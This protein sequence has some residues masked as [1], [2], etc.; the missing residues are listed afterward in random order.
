[1][2]RNNAALS[3]LVGMA[4]LFVILP[5]SADVGDIGNQLKSK[6]QGKL[7][8]LR[9]FY[10]GEHLR[11]GPDGG[12]IDQAATG[13]WTVN[14]QLVVKDIYLQGRL[15]I[16]KGNRVFLCFDSASRDLGV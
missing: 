10:A 14:A 6:Y 12:L 2:R 11:F 1:M 5:V 8:T 4:L 7:V 3:L 15:L 16:I 9:H 13:P